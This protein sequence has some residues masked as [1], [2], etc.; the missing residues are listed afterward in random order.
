MKEMGDMAL[1]WSEIRQMRCFLFYKAISG[2]LNQ[3]VIQ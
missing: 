3:L 1:Y 2:G